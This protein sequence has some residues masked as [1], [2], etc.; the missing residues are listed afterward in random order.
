VHAHGPRQTSL[1]VKPTLDILS[2]LCVLVHDV[3]F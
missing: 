2:E 3:V 1:Q